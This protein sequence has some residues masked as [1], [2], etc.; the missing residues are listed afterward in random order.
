MATTTDHQQ[1]LRSS[2]HRDLVSRQNF[3]DFFKT[4]VCRNSGVVDEIYFTSRVNIVVAMLFFRDRMGSCGDQCSNICSGD[5]GFF[6]YD[7]NTTCQCGTEQCDGDC[8]LSK[9][10]FQQIEY[11]TTAKEG[12][13]NET[14]R[15]A[16]V[17]TLGMDVP[18]IHTN[19]AILWNYFGQTNNP[20]E[21]KLTDKEY[22]FYLDVVLLAVQQLSSEAGVQEAQDLY[23]NYGK[24]LSETYVDVVGVE[25]PGTLWDYL[26]GYSGPDLSWIPHLAMLP[27][28]LANPG[29]PTL[30]D[31]R[32]AFPLP[33][34]RVLDVTTLTDKAEICKCPL[35]PSGCRV[36]G[37]EFNIL[38]CLNWPNTPK[39]YPG[40]SCDLQG[41]F[42]DRGDNVCGGI[43]VNC[44]GPNDKYQ[45]LF[46][47]DGKPVY[48][49]R[50]TYRQP[51][52]PLV[53]DEVCPTEWTSGSEACHSLAT[54]ECKNIG[55]T[56][57]EV[58]IYDDDPCC[59]CDSQDPPPTLRQLQD[60]WDPFKKFF[61]VIISGCFGK[62]F[63]GPV[64]TAQ[65]VAELAG[66]RAVQ[67]FVNDLGSSACGKR[68]DILEK[69][70]YSDS[71]CTYPYTYGSNILFDCLRTC[72]QCGLQGF[73]VQSRKQ[74]QFGQ[75]IVTQPMT[76]YLKLEGKCLRGRWDDGFKGT[77][78]WCG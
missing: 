24:A 3:L 64:T 65:E 62:L 11:L 15:Y 28:R 52:D 33:E 73:P 71:K 55:G 1:G 51:G 75:D 38:D 49:C 2:S 57:S 36:D 27:E 77:L 34:D 42:T 29:S 40:G 68:A 18:M 41:F 60:F 69:S 50:C 53:D 21:L 12:L 47:V 66:F 76:F 63:S 6:V 9:A 22:A 7:F 26:E 17:A 74:N 32:N 58:L 72:P 59:K 46:S 56:W 20:I 45:E 67:G 19:G 39:V 44:R 78:N 13:F 54:G 10:L 61:D 31:F 16:P 8:L 4:D 23:D 25:Y 37:S 30:Q 35:P 43:R 14:W 5:Y 70:L 48:C